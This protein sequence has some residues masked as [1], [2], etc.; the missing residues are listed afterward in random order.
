M[1]PVILRLE[2]RLL[3]RERA[4]WVLLALFAGAL[5]YGLWN[6]AQMAERQR[7]VSAQIEEESQAWMRQVREALDRQSVDP[8]SLAGRASTAVLPPAPMPL[9]AIGQSDLMPGFEVVSLWKPDASTSQKAELENPSLLLTGRFDLAFVLVWLFPLFLLGLIYDL[10]AGD[11]E[12]GTLRMV[13][14][15]GTRPW[16]WMSAR[17]L[18]RA[19]PV[20]GLALAATL[21]AVLRAEPSAASVHTA[22]P[23]AVVLAYGAFW[24]ALALAVNAVARNAAGAAT[25]LGATW[26]LFV[27]VMPALLN[28]A[29][30]ALYPTPS[31]AELVAETRRASGDAEKRG[32]EL[33]NS[34]YDLHPELAPPGARGDPAGRLLTV[35]A[36]V[37]EA[38]QPVRERFDAQ[39]ALQQ[40][41]VGRWRVASPAIAA[42]EALTDLAGTGYWRYRAYREQVASLRREVADFYAPLIHRRA[43][44][45]KP[46]YERLPRFVFREEDER[47]PL[48]R[49][50]IS[51]GGMLALTGLFGA[52]G[53]LR[54]RPGRRDGSPV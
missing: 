49:V 12:S 47:G 22:L 48:K 20:I 8:R 26:V 37:A 11:R 52:F 23:F 43:P 27:L 45:T 9:L 14:A 29:V 44:V 39:L 40:A 31:R 1:D 51:L 50:G 36:E 3:L 17:A 10:I 19:A 2:L 13:L 38:T 6:G 16:G 25:A 24:I 41:A 42:H 21:V 28:V 5:A 4:A 34:F 15:Q 30:E 54:L 33:L 46:D 32:N 53:W 18:V 7:T 35:Q